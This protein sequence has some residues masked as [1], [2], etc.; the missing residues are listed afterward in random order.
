MHGQNHIKFV[1]IKF[2]VHECLICHEVPA[3]AA[4][5]R[6]RIKDA[7]GTIVLKQAI[8]ILK[9]KNYHKAKG[10]SNVWRQ[11]IASK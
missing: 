5:L 3:T 4:V 2:K 6:E 1:H 9:H 10:I 7:L 11:L 8:P